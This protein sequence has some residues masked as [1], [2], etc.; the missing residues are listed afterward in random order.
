M[1]PTCA[2]MSERSASM[3][4]LFGSTKRNICRVAKPCIRAAIDFS[5]SI[6][7]GRTRS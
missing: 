3:R 7:G 6:S 5:N 1:R 4:R 2:V